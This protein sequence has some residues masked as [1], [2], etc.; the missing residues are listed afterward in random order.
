MYHVHGNPHMKP[1]PLNIGHTGVVI[2]I[3]YNK[4]RHF[5]YLLLYCLL[6]LILFRGLP[7][8]EFI[9]N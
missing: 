8:E 7:E 2:Y 5:I 4:Q 6:M 1:S 9:I 3:S